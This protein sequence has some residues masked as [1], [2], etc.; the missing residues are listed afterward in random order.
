MGL[1]TVAVDGARLEVLDLGSGEPVVFV[2][3]ALTADMLQPVAADPAL[4]DHRRIVY[5]RRGYAGSSPVDGPGSI[6][7]D[8]TDCAGLLTGLGIDRAHVVGLSYAGAVA[9]QLA[10]EL[11]EPVRSLTLVEPP[12]VHV[13]SADEFRAASERLIASRRDRGPAAALDEF[14]TTVI[15]PDWQ[16]VVE[17]PL[18]GATAQMRQ[19]V[20]TFF[21]SDLPA[22][23]AWRFGPEDAQRIRCPVLYIG[24]TDSGPWFA[25]VH[26][27]VL[28][29]L[30][31][32]EDVLIGGADHS[33]ALTHTARVA[34]ALADFLRR[35]TQ[36]TPPER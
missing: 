22:L 18:P 36:G 16:Q 13:E 26:D 24:G 8:A 34:E 21:D 2:Q 5:H 11:P 30:P 9:L 20:T 29:W 35:P 33:L 17:D 25:E 3:T 7:R 32:A 23:L 1:R 15:G 31:H 10:A 28:R 12:P 19:D 27:L 14:L 6:G 4:G